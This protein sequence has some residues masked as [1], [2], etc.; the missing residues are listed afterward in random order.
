MKPETTPVSMVMTPDPDTLPANASIAFALRKMTMEGYRHIP[1]VND[2]GS[3]AGVVAVR[4]IVAWLVGLLPEGVYNLP[5]EP[6]F[7]K[8]LDGG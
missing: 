7:P 3:P 2:D 6:G 5:P 8:N 4:D 1:L